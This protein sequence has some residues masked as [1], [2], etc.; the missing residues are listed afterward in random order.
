VDEA[1]KAWMHYQEYL[2]RYRYKYET[3]HPES[4]ESA[5]IRLHEAFRKLHQYPDMWDQYYPTVEKST[6]EAYERMIPRYVDEAEKAWMH[7]QEYLAFL[8]KRETF[9]PLSYRPPLRLTEEE[10][11][12]GEAVKNFRAAIRAL[13]MGK[14]LRFGTL[15]KRP[16]KATRRKKREIIEADEVEKNQ[17]P[18]TS[19]HIANEDDL[20][21]RIEALGE[22]LK[23]HLVP[24]LSTAVLSG[25]MPYAALLP[26]IDPRAIETAEDKIAELKRLQPPPPFDPEEPF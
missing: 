3:V 15:D 20:K 4:L 17:D 24:V 16:G 18:H 1:E 14:S 11:H 19:L 21:K 10:Y 22:K 23:E 12:Y 7:Y 2:P 9:L 5:V 8:A 26:H 25:H 13:S 6:R